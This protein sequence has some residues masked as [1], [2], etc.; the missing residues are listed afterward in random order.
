MKFSFVD[1][2][3]EEREQGVLYICVRYG[4]ASHNCFCGCGREV[5]TPFSPSQWRLIFD[6]DTVSLD[7]SIGNWSFPCR[8]HYWIRKSIIQWA[9]DMNDE[10]I[11]TSRVRGRLLQD[12]YYRDRGSGEVEAPHQLCRSEERAWWRRLVE[13]VRRRP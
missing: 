8:S 5:V 7:P 10:E 13:R 6:G 3:P 4:T 11:E 1:S 12:L 2:I 9:G